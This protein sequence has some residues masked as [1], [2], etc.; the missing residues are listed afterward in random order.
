[1]KAKV[2]VCAVLAAMA[3]SGLMACEA[4]EVKTFEVVRDTAAVQEETAPRDGEEEVLQAKTQAQNKVKADRR[5]L[6]QVTEAVLEQFEG[7][8]E[9]VLMDART[10]A[11]LAQV[12][13]EEPHGVGSTFK[14]ISTL[15]AL[16]SPELGLKPDAQMNCKGYTKFGGRHFHCWKRDGHGEVGL[17]DALA[18][19]CNSVSFELA[20][21]A[22]YDDIVTFARRFGLGEAPGP[23]L[24]PGGKL[25]SQK[26]IPK[27]VEGYKLLL[28]V[29]QHPFEQNLLQ[30]ARAYGVLAR[31]HLV[32]VHR[33]GDDWDKPTPV[34]LDPEALA[35][36]R[37]GL[38]DAVAGPKGTAHWAASKRVSV[39]GKTG[40]V[41]TGQNYRKPSADNDQIYDDAW[42]AGYAPADEPEVVVVVRVKGGVSGG[43]TAAPVARELLEAWHEVR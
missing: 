11:L 24:A 23:G 38:V 21:H 33:P 3:S 13:G 12:G 28:S 19:S 34:E 6:Q 30:M 40:T 42:F 41:W 7:R 16:A 29:G 31:G 15:A 22:H 2:L 18:Q 5:I 4:P 20:S 25:L 1:M 17:D 39:A 26:D 8:G 37:K 9:A 32:Q 14:P 10:G 36:V 43:K 35:M 27:F